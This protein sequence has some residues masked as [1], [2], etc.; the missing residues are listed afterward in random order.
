[1]LEQVNEDSERLLANPDW[2][3]IPAQLKVPRVHFKD[4]ETP[5]LCEIFLRCQ[6]NHPDP[7]ALSEQSSTRSRLLNAAIGA[8]IAVTNSPENRSLRA[9]ADLTA[10]LPRVH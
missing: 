3:T 8:I 2:H 9:Y 5:D 1:M 6:G 7:R 4:A 10:D